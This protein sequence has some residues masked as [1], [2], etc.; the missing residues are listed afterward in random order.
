MNPNKPDMQ[1]I[2]ISIACPKDAREILEIYSPYVTDTAITFEYTVPKL[3]EFCQRI[4]QILSRF[5]YIIARTAAGSAV[6]YAYASPF[7]ERAAYQWAVE[8]SIYVAKDFRGSGVGRSLHN[9]LENLLKEQNILNMNACIAYPKTPDPYLDDHSVQFHR[10]MGYRI[11][12][13]FYQC[14]YKFNRWYDMVWMEKHIGKHLE[15]PKKV[16][17]FN[18]IKEFVKEIL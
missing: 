7:H 2:Q 14:G 16:K 4:E 8:T 13:Q 10:H 12:G 15:N 6:G 18:E 5:P 17:T 11:V 9:M 3:E 1:K